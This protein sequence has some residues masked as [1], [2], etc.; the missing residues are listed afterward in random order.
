M[1]TDKT[2]HR[3]SQLPAWKSVLAV[4]AHPDDESFGLGA[5]LSTF[6]DGGARGGVLCFTHGE[7][8]TLHGVAG[9]LRRI[10]TA[11]LHCA[12]DALGLHTVELASYPDGALDQEPLQHLTDRIA[13]VARTESVEGL[14]VF[15]TTGITGHPDHRWATRAAV[16]AGALMEI[17]V[18]AWTLPEQVTEVLN[19]ELRTSFRGRPAD[20]IDLVI[21]VDRSRQLRAGEAH[22]SQD[23]PGTPLWRR[24]EL[25]EGHECLRWLHPG[26]RPSPV[27]L[28]FT[29]GCPSWQDT[30]AHLIQALGAL[31]LDDEDILLSVV[32]DQAQA[33]DLYFAGSPTVLINGLD[34]FTQPGR[35]PALACRLYDTPEGRSG[36]PTLTQV[37]IALQALRESR[38]G[39][40]S[41]QG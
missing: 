15:D 17:P 21:A 14:I 23:V 31:G 36:T 37:T 12:A 8:S 18:L 10:R 25:L 3:A 13:A 33:E 4:V 6:V 34:P 19:S 2:A 26:T 9:E 11:E 20:E 24:L 35:Q 40:T 27:E 41:A 16:A 22:R 30:Y 28:Q 5:V 1:E 29:A 7:A 32:Q 38:L 39:A